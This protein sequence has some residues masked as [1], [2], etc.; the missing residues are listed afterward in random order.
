MNSSLVSSDTIIYS[1]PI[2]KYCSKRNNWENLVINH[3][4]LRNTE[5]NQKE[6]E[7]LER[8]YFL[9]ES[10]ILEEIDDK[11]S[12]YKKEDLAN[13]IESEKIKGSEKDTNTE[14]TKS[15]YFKLIHSTNEKNSR[16]KVE[17]IKHHPQLNTRKASISEDKPSYKHILFSKSTLKFITY[18]L[19]FNDYNWENRINEII[20]IIAK[21]D[22][23]VICLQEV[24]DNFMNKLK[25]S[26][27]IRNNYYITII[28]DQLRSWYDIAILTKFAC[29]AYMFPF[30]SKMHRKLLYITFY[31]K[32][33]DLIKIGTTHLESMN[34]M[35]TRD[36]QL[37][38]SYQFLE[39]VDRDFYQKAKYYFLLG[40]FNFTERENKYIINNG[41]KD[42]AL[43]EMEKTNKVVD[44]FNTMKSMKGYPAWRPDRFTYKSYSNKL[45]VKSFEI[46][47]KEAMVKES[48]FNPIGTP[49]D[50]YGLFINCDL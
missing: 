27:F 21:K 1:C 49:S 26:E 13:N 10:D 37:K 17:S 50:H 44:H 19:W 14:S 20:S 2:I 15:T 36:N 9:D 4:D 8:V 6:I 5:P 35:Y 30:M 32:D 16:V 42:Y 28:P 3:N 22:P 41:Y 38:A 11:L 25:N 39:N 7:D 33:N 24:T 45:K 43:E 23:D 48:F 34:N 47:G 18:N 12:V 46:I 40:D 31:N 29:K